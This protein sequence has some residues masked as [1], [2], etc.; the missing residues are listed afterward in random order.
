[1]AEDRQRRPVVNG[2]DRSPNQ[3]HPTESNPFNLKPLSLLERDGER[4]L[5]ASTYP[6]KRLGRIVAF[7]IRLMDFA[8]DIEKINCLAHRSLKFFVPVSVLTFYTT[9]SSSFQ[10]FG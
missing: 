1:M 9:I 6:F 2:D 4:N 10:D 7:Q 5:S 8:K 3:S